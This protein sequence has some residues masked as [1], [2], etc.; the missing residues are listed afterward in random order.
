MSL[1]NDLEPVNDNHQVIVQVLSDE[2]KNDGGYEEEKDESRAI[3][4]CVFLP[5]DTLG[6]YILKTFLKLKDKISSDPRVHNKAS[7]KV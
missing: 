3:G 1:D 7:I 2:E 5:I 6:P 4:M